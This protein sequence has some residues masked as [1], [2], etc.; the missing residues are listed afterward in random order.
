MTGRYSIGRTSTEL[1]VHRNTLRRMTTDG[2]I[3]VHHRQA[4]GKSFYLGK[5]ILKVWYR[6]SK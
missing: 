1:G 3:P 6:E 2:I 5:D 4:T